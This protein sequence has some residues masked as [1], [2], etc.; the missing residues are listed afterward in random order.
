[1]SDE[2]I[3][4][5]LQKNKLALFTSKYFFT[6]YVFQISIIS[7]ENYFFSHCSS[8]ITQIELLV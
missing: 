6:A 8:S 1:M 2:Y 7:Q 4:F 5:G 3:A